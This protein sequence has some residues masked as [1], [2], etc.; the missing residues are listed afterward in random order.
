M[1]RIALRIGPLV[2]LMVLAGCASY[3]PVDLPWRE[4]P[5]GGE[6]ATHTTMHKGDQV[7]VTTIGSRVAE[8]ILVEYDGLQV[9]VVDTVGT[10]RLVTV[11][12]DSVSQVE[13]Y[14]RDRFKNVA[15]AMLAITGAAGTI[16][17]VDDLLDDDATFTPDQGLAR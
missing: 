14:Q 9:T 7:R 6:F 2:V 15:M 5:I 8:G 3:H 11:P 12:V 13:V 1:P 10:V 16:W 17:I 4:P